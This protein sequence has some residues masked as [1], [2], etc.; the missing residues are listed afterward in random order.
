[1]F[2]TWSPQKEA[3]MAYTRKLM[4]AAVVA[5]IIFTGSATAQVTTYT[6]TDLGTLPGGTDSRAEGISPNG[7][8]VGYSVV[9]GLHIATAW[10]GGVAQNLGVL[11]GGDTQSEARFANASGVIVGFSTNTAN[12]ADKAVSFT[13]GGS[14]TNLNVNAGL[15]QPPT[16]A[17]LANSRAEAINAAG[18]IVG[19]VYSGNFNNLGALDGLRGFYRSAAGVVTRL[20]S[21]DGVTNYPAS[22]SLSYGINATSQVFGQA[23]PQGANPGYRG[24]RWSSPSGATTT[25]SFSYPAASGAGAAD[26]TDYLGFQGNNANRLAGT[27]QN[28][29]ASRSQAFA[30]DGTTTTL[31]NNLGGNGVGV[32]GNAHSINNALVNVIVGSSDN[33]ANGL[34]ATAWN[35]SGTNP[36]PTAINLNSRV[37]AG[38]SFG[39]V[40]AF[41]INDLGQIVGYGIVAGHE[42]AFLLTPVPEPGTLVLC[43]LGV[44]GLAARIRRRKA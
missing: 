18:E 42:H 4:S 31:L 27:A 24:A 35:W 15:T 39:L 13:I 23:D 28:I 21:P 34:T 10:V 32:F 14:P 20:D 37:V 25:P 43:G 11:A 19:H 22:A 36:D 44:A 6:L 41:G 17:T 33:G 8:V 5:S 9:G 40:E 26:I 7:V 3:V 2:A 1:M 38:A 16:G 29:D 30:S 12:T